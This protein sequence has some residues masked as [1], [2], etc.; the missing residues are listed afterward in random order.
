VS[1]R[2]WTEGVW[3]GLS[4]LRQNKVRA[5][6]TVLGVAIGVLVVMVIAAVIQGINASFTEAI[7]AAGPR[8]FY[9]TR[10]EPEVSLST[11]L[12]E[13]LPDWITR[14]TF[15]PALADAIARLPSVRHAYPFADLGWL[16]LRAE[17]GRNEAQVAIQALPVTFL[18]GDLGQVTDGRWYTA[19]EDRGGR[20]V[21]VLD[22]ATARTL[23]EPL[24]AV[25]RT[26]RIAGQAF[27]V[28]GVYDP[29]DNLFAQVG[30]HRVFMPFH[31]A[32]KHIQ[33]RSRWFGF[34]HFVGFVVIAERG[35]PLEQA[36]DDVTGL[37]RAW[38]KLRPGEPNDFAVLT[39]DQIQEVWNNLTVALFAVMI[40]LSSAGLLVGGVGVIAVMVVA[41]TERTREIGIRK[42]M[43]ATRRD[44]LWQFLVEAATLTGV[45]AF[46]G[47]LAG[48]LVV[49]AVAAWSPVPA[50]VP[51]WAVLVA[52][53]AATFTGIVFGLFPAVRAAR[54]DPVAALRYE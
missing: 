50:S 5:G 4:A 12:E 7:E 42:A 6:L 29:P 30:V 33:I 23:F 13:E 51:P 45:G 20:P 54:L 3:I 24:S 15:D 40:A 8:T 26:V 47:L 27:R 39:Q 14:P 43:G 19:E 2:A 38:R 22:S 41:V 9:V 44:I 21:V 49:W 25:G 10:T 37:V 11:G 46:A 16:S 34:D 53:A 36:V 32:R 18:Y 28:V 1:W 31:T 48:S 52:L 17:A 35:V